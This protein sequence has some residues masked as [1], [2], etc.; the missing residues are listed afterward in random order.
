MIEMGLV[1]E[2][3]SLLA[4]PQGLSK[5]A[6]QAVGYAEIIEHLQGNLNLDDAVEKIKINTRRLAKAQRTWFRT[7]QKV[8]WI[9]LL[10][11][12]HPE[13]IAEKIINN[14]VITRF[15]NFIKLNRTVNRLV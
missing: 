14:L 11:N 10:P 8:L 7:F 4:E 13:K 2:V 3:K 5:Q 1:D 15:F 12:D 9:D 6:A